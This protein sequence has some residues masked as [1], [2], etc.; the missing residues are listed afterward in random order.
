MNKSIEDKYGPQ[1]FGD[2]LFTRKA[3]L[4]Q[5]YYRV[6]KLKEKEFGIGPNENSVYKIKDAKGKPTREEAPSYH[7]NML[8]NGDKSGSNFLSTDIF[9]YVKYRLQFLKKGETINAY[10]IFNNMLSSQPMCFNLF[11]PL[12]E[13]FEKEYK[14]ANKVFKACF[15]SLKIDK[16]L[17]VE[18][19]YLPYPVSEYLNDRTAFDAMLI[20]KTA[21]GERNILAI[22]TKY[23]EKLGTNPSSDLSKQIDLVKNGTLFN[24]VGKNEVL[25]GFSQLGRNF[26]LAEKFRMENRLDKAYAVVI[27]PKENASSQTEIT[28]FQGNM[29]PEFHDRLFYIS[30]Q[31]FIKR[32][33]NKPSKAIKNW[34][35]LFEKRYLVFNDCE[36][37]Y[38]EYKKQ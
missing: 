21:S 33:N 8:V 23:V 31:D 12:K 19:E 37:I 24:E 1:S 4:L 20:Y 11:Y 7:G 17:A 25:N 32:I 29:N 3:R 28:D 18:I 2:N 13:L 14:V 9:D 22:E 30:L 34:I 38:K 36:S 26:L 27:A 10:R 16:I 35:E 15:P 6:E 5:S